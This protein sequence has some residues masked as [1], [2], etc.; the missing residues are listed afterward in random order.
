MTP[1]TT[2]E[3]AQAGSKNL[4]PTCGT[5]GRS[6][7]PITIT[8]LVADSAKARIGREDGFFFCTEPSC[9]VAYF[10]PEA[11]ERI[12]K[13]EVK[14]RIGQKE[15]SAP[16]PVCYCFNH[17]VE[18]IE[19]EVVRTGGSRMPD[20]IVEKCKKGLDRCEETNPQGRCCLGNVQKAV[21][22]ALAGRGAVISSAAKLRSRAGVLAQ[23]GALVSAVVASA[24]CWL[25]LL[26][27]AFGVSGSAVAAK[28]EAFRP[29]LLPVT[30]ALLGVA[31]YFA[32]R[33]PKV[34]AAGTGE[35]C[36]LPQAGA[37]PGP[38]AEASSCCAPNGEK[39]F[40]MKKLNKAMLWVVTAV[41][42]A[43]AFF[44]NYVGYLIDGGDT[45]ADKSELVGQVRW[46]LAIEGMTCEGC[47]KG[48]Q[49]AVSNLPGVSQATVSYE[50]KEAE[51]AGN[52]SLTEEALRKVVSD[53]GYTTRSAMRR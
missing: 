2:S 39:G 53:A 33:K 30:F 29:V 42:L 47:A 48:L 40:T 34:V 17:T 9:N 52:S 10:N 37:T 44:P 28:F 13:G 31:F 36:C 5:K 45:L 27:I 7:K 14:V 50:R 49:A 51:V 8:S 21:K 3:S 18:E 1:S 41:V 11:G 15:P 4:C 6:V 22:D 23:A 35:S 24:C 20:E 38:A 25:P 19:E 16:R 26:L 32:Y 12:G 46:T 43:F